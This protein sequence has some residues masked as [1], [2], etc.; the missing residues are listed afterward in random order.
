MVP[1]SVLRMWVLVLQDM[2][3]GTLWD[4]TTPV[5]DPY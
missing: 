1:L 4:D 3:R 5:A 2:C